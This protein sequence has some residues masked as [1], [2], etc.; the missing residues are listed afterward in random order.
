GSPLRVLI[1]MPMGF[2]NTVGGSMLREGVELW[3]RLDCR[4]QITDRLTS[5]VRSNQYDAILISMGRETRRAYDRGWSDIAPE[6]RAWIAE[7]VK[8]GRSGLV[9]AYPKGPTEE[10]TGVFEP[11]ARVSSESLLRGFP[12]A[13]MHGV[14]GSN[15]KDIY[16]CYALDDAFFVD[17]RNL[18]EN[19]I[20]AFSTNGV[21][22]VRLNYQ[23]KGAWLP[24]MAFTPD[25]EKIVPAT[26]THYD[27]W[28]SLLARAVLFAAGREN[29]TVIRSVEL[30]DDSWTVNVDR[31]PKGATLWYR[32]RDLWGRVYAEGNVRLSKDKTILAGKPLPPRTAL[33]VVAKDVNGKALDWY[34]AC[35][36]PASAVRIAKV[37]LDKDA[38]RKGDTISGKATVVADR[39]DDYTLI[40]YLADHKD[41]RLVSRNIPCALSQG[42]TTHAFEL[43]IPNSSD[44]L[45][46]RV[47]AL[48]MDG[49]RIV[50]RRG[51]DCPIPD[52]KFE[53]FYAQ[54]YGGGG[55]RLTERQSALRFRDEFGMNGVMG[56]GIL[57]ARN[58]FR[59]IDYS[60]HLGYVNSEEGL[61]AFLQDWSAFF[62]ANFRTPL[63]EVKKYRPVFYSLGEEHTFMLQGSTN[64]EGVARFQG[65]LKE[66][67]AGDLAHL[68]TV[69]GTNYASWDQIK[70]GPPEVVDMLKFKPDIQKFE[71]RRFFERLFAVKHAFLA[72][73][74]RKADPLAQVGIHAA[75]DTWSGRGYDFWLLSK[76]MDSMMCYEGMQNQYA[77]SFFK[78]YYGFNYHYGPGNEAEV[79]WNCWYALISGAHGISWYSMTP[80]FWG[81]TATDLNLSSDWAASASEFRAMR[82]IGDLLTRTEYMQD[83]VAIHY[84][85][86]SLWRG[87]VD[88]SWWHNNYANLF[89]DA[90][91]PFRFV[92]YEQLGEG[93]LLKKRYPLFMMVHSISL[94][95]AEA[96]AVRDFVA[97]GGT[98][99]A[100]L[101][102]GEYDNFGRKLVQPQLADL[103]TNLTDVALEG[104][105]PL[106]VGKR[107]QGTVI[108][109]DIG[110]YSYDRNVGNHL[111]AQAVVDRAIGLAKA[112]RAARVVDL[113]TKALANGVWTAGYRQ[114][115]Q[116]YVVMAKDHQLADRT[117]AAVAVEFGVKGHI[118]DMR[119][120]KYCGLL[121][122]VETALEPTYGKAFSV[123]PYLVK[124]IRAKI[125]A[126]KRG[127]DL[128]AHVELVADGKIEA[129]E[130]H[131]LQV[132]AFGPDGKEVTAMRRF[133]GIRV[134]KGEV[135][136]PIAVDDPSGRW[137][138]VLKDMATGLTQRLAYRL[139]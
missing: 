113:K 13:L 9:Y 88:M 58:N 10:L 28:Q 103:F 81:A 5:E 95:A 75:W 77:R 38:Y 54:V 29:P 112:S 30:S 99:W 4:C 82:E 94:S 102:P 14:D 105:K 116:R 134:G 117:K 20:E 110:N 26:D 45:L 132:M 15:L 86:D 23:K 100:D 137:T 84:S 133:V 85:S 11:K 138:V 46:M 12:T 22:S 32:A 76:A 71:S 136:L 72:D 121:D 83:Q 91:V 17:R 56:A 66:K 48:L 106:K 52:E 16:I 119:A 128:V 60:T 62:P 125:G 120:G 8:S 55:N 3:Q 130:T 7:R 27:Y 43:T 2:Y 53:G 96:K 74:I 34:S 65:Y 1:V 68:N 18:A 111:P 127:E 109:G 19:V 97:Q 31:A 24:N 80:E 39:A 98:I 93:E 42:E 61:T 135:R 67:Y 33:D 78:H 70:M 49:A 64:A 104:G 87:V 129:D 101:I 35:T 107:G 90:G 118:Y 37:A 124:K 126:V 122:K 115:R 59:S 6:L 123:L 21:R 73:Y 51:A 108:L 92:S 89:Y 139:P 47:D 44:S 57:R 40:V 69:W 131:F 25:T 36:P 79:R 114:G 50:D 63:E 41:R